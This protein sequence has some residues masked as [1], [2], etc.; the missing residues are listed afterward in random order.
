MS[1]NNNAPSSSV[2][3]NSL[4]V[5]DQ[6]RDQIEE[7]AEG[8]FKHSPV[9]FYCRDCKSIVKCNEKRK[10]LQC[11]ECKQNNVSIGTERSIKNYYKIHDA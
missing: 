11:K 6:A 7:A 5:S 8:N 2:R 9:V 10:K 1:D 4:N 3:L